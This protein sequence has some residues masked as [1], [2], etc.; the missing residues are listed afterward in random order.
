[1]RRDY[2]T[3]EV[4]DVAWVE[5]GSEP[6]RPTLVVNFEGPASL[7]RDRLTGEAAEPLDREEIDVGFRFQSASDREDAE[8]VVSVTDRMTGEYLLELNAPAS[9]ILHFI[10]AAREFSEHTGED[11]RYEIEINI[12][13]S[14]VVTYEKRTFLVYTKDGNLMREHSLIPSGVEL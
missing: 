5:D 12:G 13:G 9:D 6:D 11:D 7:L 1:M 4:R 14:P 10:L 2:F 3:L 8:G